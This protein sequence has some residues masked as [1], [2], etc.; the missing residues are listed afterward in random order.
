MTL[1]AQ[2]MR[3]LLPKGGYVVTWH[4]YIDE[5]GTTSEDE[6]LVL[7][8]YIFDDKQFAALDGKWADMLASHP[9]AD[10]T[11][12]PYFHMS[13]CAHNTK[14]FKKYSRPQCDVVARE[15][16]G[17]IREHM[18]HG[19]AV[20][21]EKRHA[22]LLPQPDLPLYSSLYSFACWTCLLMIHDWL[23]QQI[24]HSDDVLYFFEQGHESQTE[25]SN[26]MTNIM[27]LPDLREFY[28]CIG[29]GFYDKRTVRPLQ[30]A[31]ILAWQW[32]TQCKRTRR[33]GIPSSVMHQ[34]AL[35]SSRKDLIELIRDRSYSIKT[36]DEAMTRRT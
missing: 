5:S 25:A 17:L 34:V 12:L 23:K 13:S 21:F 14:V 11:P 4:A 31:D 9:G 10:G 18:S 29:H 15:A 27:A 24:A 36:G 32:L 35:D 20:A 7:A 3:A 33:Q 22:H 30:C 19:F 8:G 26:L 2:L 16:I 1:A 28:H 6:W